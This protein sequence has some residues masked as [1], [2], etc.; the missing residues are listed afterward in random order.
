LTEIVRAVNHDIRNHLIKIYQNSLSIKNNLSGLIRSSSDKERL[1]LSLAILQRDID[2]SSN[3]IDLFSP[4]SFAIS[5]EDF[6]N[7]IYSVKELFADQLKPNNKS[8]G[9][10]IIIQKGDNSM[11]DI[12]CS[13]AELS[14]IVYNLISNAKNAIIE[15]WDK[16]NRPTTIPTGV[17][18]VEFDYNPVDKAYLLSVADT[19]S[20]IDNENL[21]KVYE[22]GFTTRKDGLG[23]GLYF[24]KETIEKIYN[25]SIHCKSYINKGTTFELKFKQK[26]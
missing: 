4:D 5:V 12:R 19:G 20:G 25:G 18:N 7:I 11:P 1:N 8:E 23:I 10:Q 6:S 21:A 13:K 15:K 26:I 24:V 2:N 16:L 17:I 22:L 9:I 3:L 14:M